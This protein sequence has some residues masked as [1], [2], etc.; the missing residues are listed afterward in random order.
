MVAL[1]HLL[2]RPVQFS[3]LPL[4]CGCID[5]DRRCAM[6]RSAQRRSKSWSQDAA[7]RIGSAVIVVSGIYTLLR[8]R[9]RGLPL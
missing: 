7:T 4:G 3:T 1:Q 5:G 6:R 8:S 2:L 9:T